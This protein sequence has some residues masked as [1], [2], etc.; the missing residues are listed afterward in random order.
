M[1]EE[2]SLTMAMGYMPEYYGF[3]FIEAAVKA[4]N[5][6]ELPSFYPSPVRIVTK[7][8]FFDFYFKEGDSYVLNIGAVAALDQ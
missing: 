5:G 2:G 7:D 6:E 4:A 8:N 1:I 3:K